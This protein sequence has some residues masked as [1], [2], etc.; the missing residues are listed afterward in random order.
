MVSTRARHYLNCNQW[1]AWADP[2]KGVIKTL[3]INLRMHKARGAEL[4]IETAARV[5]DLYYRKA[6]TV[7]QILY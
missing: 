7:M 1:T 6:Y 4:S 5:S 3:L 2:K